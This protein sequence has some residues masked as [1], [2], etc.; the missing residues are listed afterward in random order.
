MVTVAPKGGT[1]SKDL[2]TY[3]VRCPNGTYA[4]GFFVT[5]DMSVPLDADNVPDDTVI[6]TTWP[7]LCGNTR[8]DGL[9]LPNLGS[10]SSSVATGAS[11]GFVA[12]NM[13][14]R[15]LV[16]AIRHNP[17]DSL[18]GGWFGA[19]AKNRNGKMS[20]VECPAGYVITGVFGQASTTHMVTLGL[21][22]QFRRKK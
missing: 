5:T 13:Y 16:T 20:T 3:D 1:W 11:A 7:L 4:S 15:Q 6:Q 21:H 18:P 10:T 2:S 17:A 8:V 14:A 22:C 19:S 12:I 9:E